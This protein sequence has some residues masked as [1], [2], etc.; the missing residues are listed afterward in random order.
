MTSG[1]AHVF[2]HSV[3]R[4]ALP[5]ADANTSLFIDTLALQLEIEE[6][7]LIDLVVVVS[8]MVVVMEK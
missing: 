5:R 8:L 6:E 4:I 1:L 3:A 7:L 2:W